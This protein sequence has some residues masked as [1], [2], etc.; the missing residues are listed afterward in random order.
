MIL[1]FSTLTWV[2]T[3]ISIVALVAGYYVT[4][5]LF[6]SQKLPT[7]TAIFLLTSVATGVTGFM[8]PFDK[9][10]PSHWT[11][12]IL[13]VLLAG[14][15][16]AL[17]VFRLAGAWRWIY[18]VC[19]VLA[20]YLNVFVLVVQFFTK[21]PAL[22]ALAPTQSEPPFAIAQGVVLLAFIAITIATAIKFR[23]VAAA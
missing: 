17:Y 8:F 19:A 1:G 13:L 15:V 22:R 6:R 3:L 10:G 12:V 23:P 5:G 2:H 9:F 21:V 4:A 7:W 18:A 11:G 20:F 16:L 14:A